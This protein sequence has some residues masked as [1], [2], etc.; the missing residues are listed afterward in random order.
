[1]YAN[2]FEPVS[3]YPNPFTIT[4]GEDGRDWVYEEETHTLRIL[5]N[6][7]TAISGGAGTDANQSPFSGRIAL[8]DQIR[9]EAAA[10]KE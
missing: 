9:R 2:A 3:L 8:A 7:V 4:G 5:S 10:L 1:M 6:Q